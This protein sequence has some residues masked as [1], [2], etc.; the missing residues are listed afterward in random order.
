MSVLE[1]LC[2]SSEKVGLGAAGT[3]STPNYIRTRASKDTQSRLYSQGAHFGLMA[4]ARGRVR[5]TMQL[6]TWTPRDDGFPL[7]FL[8]ANMAVFL[9]SMVGIINGWLTDASLWCERAAACKYLLVREVTHAATLRV[10]TLEG[11][12]IC[13]HCD[14][15][16]LRVRACGGLLGGPHTHVMN[17]PRGWFWFGSRLR[18]V[19]FWFGKCV[20]CDKFTWSIP[21]LLVR[22]YT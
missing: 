2:F 1:S 15:F 10:R 21:R 9:L 11:L 6:R 12:L 7:P 4:R 22:E 18:P 8:D 14:H 19:W 5:E 3:V 20:V 17:A 16:G 13:S